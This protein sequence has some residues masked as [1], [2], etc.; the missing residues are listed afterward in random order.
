MSGL[1]D[2]QAAGLEVGKLIQ[3]LRLFHDLFDE[4][5]CEVDGNGKFTWVNSQW[6]KHLGWTCEE[7]TSRPWIDFI[8]ADDRERT[9]AAYEMMSTCGVSNFENR[10]QHKDGKKYLRLRWK[11][12]PFNGSGIA[13]AKAEIIGTETKVIYAQQRRLVE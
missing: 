4:L 13:Y 2:I 6:E 5:C 12:I 11:T 9:M 1:Q 10:Y 8:H 3:R 7:L